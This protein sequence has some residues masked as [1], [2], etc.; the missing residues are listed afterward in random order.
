ME[1]ALVEHPHGGLKHRVA[2]QTTLLLTLLRRAK[3]RRGNF[4]VQT[5]AIRSLKLT[6]AHLYDIYTG[7]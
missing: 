7:E 6:Q 4:R 5:H 1:T 2:L 3:G